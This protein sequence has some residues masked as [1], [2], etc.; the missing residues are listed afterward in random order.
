MVLQKGH[1]VA[2]QH[3][4]TGEL[5]IGASVSMTAPGMIRRSK[6][7]GSEAATTRPSNDS[8]HHAS[9][10]APPV[11]KANANDLQQRL[12]ELDAQRKSM[13]PMEQKVRKEHAAAEA[14]VQTAKHKETRSQEA[15]ADARKAEATRQELV[16]GEAA[17]LMQ[18][19]SRY[20]Q[21]EKDFKQR[22][23]AWKSELDA[24]VLEQAAKMTERDEVKAKCSRLEVDVRQQEA[25]ATELETL[26]RRTEEKCAKERLRVDLLTQELEARRQQVSDEQA[27]VQ[28][29]A[30]ELATSSSEAQLWRRTALVLSALASTLLLWRLTDP[31][32]W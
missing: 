10:V 32:M 26:A 25:H 12:L 5:P 16:R 27:E 28:R 9:Q 15:L 11:R 14:A 18:E 6:R 17:V 24:L 22:C 19:L 1:G 20:E 7:H 13:L 29:L 2:A 31:A 21:S 30:A 3:L 8:P 4:P 23:A